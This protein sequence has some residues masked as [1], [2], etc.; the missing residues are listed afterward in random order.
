MNKKLLLL[1]LLGTAFYTLNA[2]QDD[3]EE[4]RLFLEQR[5]RIAQKAPFPGKAEKKLIQE[6]VDADMPDA[7]K[8]KKKRAIAS[9]ILCMKVFVDSN[10]TQ[11][12]KYKIFENSGVDEHLLR[13]CSQVLLKKGNK[14]TQEIRHYH[15]VINQMFKDRGEK[16]KLSIP[17]AA[18]FKKQE[19]MEDGIK[20]KKCGGC[21][22]IFYCSQEC[23]K[24]DWKKHKEVCK[25]LPQLGAEA[26]A[27]K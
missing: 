12:E 27:A 9:I 3:S 25:P 19:N 5:L 18:C 21:E 11:E 16:T 26:G 13:R 24:I 7:S 20:M 14:N 22:S 10:A 8:N 23:Q 6:F 4:L 17:C 15:P 2:A 1:G